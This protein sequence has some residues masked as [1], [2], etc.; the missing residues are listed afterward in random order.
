MAFPVEL[1]SQAASEL[2]NLIRDT[3]DNVQSGNPVYLRDGMPDSFIGKLNL[4]TA[5]RACRKWASEGVGKDP[6][7][8]AAMDKFCE[9][10]LTSIS[11]YPGEPSFGAPFTGGQCPEAYR[12]FITVTRD[13]DGVVLLGPS[14]PAEN[15]NAGNANVWQGP[16]QGIAVI[17]D[18]GGSGDFGWAITDATGQIYGTFNRS[19][20]DFTPVIDS[21]AT[22]S[23]NPDNCGNPEGEYE[24]PT[25]RPDPGPPPPTVINPEFEVEID[26]D[27]N[28]EGD[29]T[30]RFG[31][32]G[33]TEVTVDP[34]NGDSDEPG[35]IGTA[36]PSEDTGPGGDSE[37]DS[38]DEILVG[39]R[40]EVI[41]IPLKANISFSG[42]IPIYRGA[43]YVFLGSE[44][45]TDLQPE[46]S[47]LRS[48]QF[49]YAPE[50]STHWLVSANMGYNL[51]V[52]PYFKPK[53][54][55]PS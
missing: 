5:R 21:V 53:E 23:G 31:G 25:P 29:I 37:G 19:S 45:N 47:T 41:D 22:I 46:G 48:G 8:D 36:Q 20:P 15:P 17:Q 55:T 16:I 1:A 14:A 4:A 33:G 43:V 42:G 44:D 13:S 51:R 40:V 50:N 3:R 6:G 11:E 52:T 10:Y 49:F 24:P 28:D 39:V 12:V 26:V 18:P 7:N 54:V 38:G 2:V 32:D 35:D 34:T 30:I 9:P 27:F